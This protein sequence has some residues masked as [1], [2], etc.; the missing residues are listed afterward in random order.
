[1][2]VVLSPRRKGRTPAPAAPASSPAAGPAVA[3]TAVPGSVARSV[4]RTAGRSRLS[5]VGCVL[6]MLAPLHAVLSSG[7]CAKSPPN[8]G[9]LSNF[10]AASHLPAGGLLSSRQRIC[11]ARRHCA[12][13][14]GSSGGAGCHP[15][16]AAGSA[17]LGQEAAVVCGAPPLA[18][19][20]PGHQ[21]C[22]HRA[23]H[24][25]DAGQRSQAGLGP[26]GQGGHSSWPG[27]GAR[28]GDASPLLCLHS[29]TDSDPAGSRNLP[30]ASSWPLP[31]AQHGADSTQ[32]LLSTIAIQTEAEDSRGGVEQERS[33]EAAAS[34]DGSLDAAGGLACAWTPGACRAMLG[35]GTWGDSPLTGRLGLFVAGL[36]LTPAR[37]HLLQ[38]L[39][40]RLPTLNRWCHSSSTSASWSRPRPT[41]RRHASWPP[42]CGA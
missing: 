38:R 5:Q 20:H 24:A 30:A 11:C 36:L 15:R 42:S 21:D 33:G 10:P 9:L 31:C 12:H 18:A 22:D 4:P 1:M 8:P 29:R 27:R 3:Q 26:G 19:T 39:R 7:G 32:R 34:D 41:T 25:D 13:P 14:P 17:G 23:R 6:G 35:G 40:H 28:L 2:R 16:E 37:H